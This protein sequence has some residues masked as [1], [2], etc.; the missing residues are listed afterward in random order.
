MKPL[1]PE[2]RKELEMIL[3]KVEPYPEDDPIWNLLD[4]EYDND[5]AMATLAKMVLEGD[6][7]GKRRNESKDQI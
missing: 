7:K 5:R 6:C 4:G 1:T 2:Q 3:A